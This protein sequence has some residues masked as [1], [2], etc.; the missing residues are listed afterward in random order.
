MAA[1]EREVMSVLSF[2]VEELMTI[3]TAGGRAALRAVK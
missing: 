3:E 1:M 2:P